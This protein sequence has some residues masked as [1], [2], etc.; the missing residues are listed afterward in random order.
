MQFIAI[1]VGNSQ[2]AS[3]MG[4]TYQSDLRLLVKTERELAARVDGLCGRLN[5]IEDLDEDERSEAYAILQALRHD[6]QSGLE[7]LQLLIARAGEETA[8]V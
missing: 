8:N 3:A 5:R 7:T 2:A 1:S 6:G 4:G